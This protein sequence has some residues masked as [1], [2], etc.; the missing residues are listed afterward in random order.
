M[1]PAGVSV[2]SPTFMVSSH[3]PSPMQF[4]PTPWGW[5]TTSPTMTMAVPGLTLH[6]FWPGAR[7]GRRHKRVRGN[8]ALQALAGQQPPV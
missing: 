3:T 5:P 7:Q 1:S 4:P 8:C 6:D 2:H